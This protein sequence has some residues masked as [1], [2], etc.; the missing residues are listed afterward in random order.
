M[1]TT[2]VH[3]AQRQTSVS[4]NL[5]RIGLDSC[6]CKC[7]ST[8]H[9]AQRDKC[10]GNPGKNTNYFE[11]LIFFSPATQW[12]KK[13]IQVASPPACHSAILHFCGFQWFDQLQIEPVAN[14][15]KFTSTVEPCF[16]ETNVQESPGKNY[17]DKSG[18]NFSNSGRSKYSRTATW[19]L[20]PGNI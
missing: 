17:I 4:G 14:R 3:F 20:Y 18:P 12:Q 6:K 7:T 11:I 5:A 10:S 9:L 13:T 8:V 19:D 15:C 2:I 16:D 1:H